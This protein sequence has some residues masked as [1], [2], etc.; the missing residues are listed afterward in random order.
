MMDY[1]NTYGEASIDKQI[2]LHDRLQH[3]GLRLA[4]SDDEGWYITLL[5]QDDWPITYWVKEYEDRS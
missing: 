5:D 1:H 3:L 4:C 2:S